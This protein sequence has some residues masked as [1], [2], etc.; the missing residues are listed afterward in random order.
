MNSRTVLMRGVLG[1]ISAPRQATTH[2][3]THAARR[4]AWRHASVVAIE[5]RWILD[6]ERSAAGPAL[7]RSRASATC[8]APRRLARL[9]LLR[10]SPTMKTILL[11]D[12]EENLRTLVRTTL[13]QPGYRILESEDGAAALELARRER[14]DVVVL[15]W[16]MPGM[17]G[18][19]VLTALRRDQATARIPI[20]L[21]TAKGQR[22]DHQQAVA[23]GASAYLMKPF[24]PLQL[25]TKVEE[26]CRECDAIAAAIPPVAD[27]LPAP[28]AADAPGGAQLALYARDLARMV[29][30]EIWVRDR[31]IGMSPEAMQD[32]FTKFY[33]VDKAETRRI[34]GTGLGLALVKEIANAHGGRV[35]V[36][37]TPGAGSTFYLALP[38][39]DAATA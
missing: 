14:P 18:M 30:A 5:K 17:T 31:G 24:S 27:A 2:A 34:G 6:A 25:L 28:A 21:L 33:R 29:D 16:M 11:A 10:T 19:E 37:S 38:S 4:V 23:S 13:D 12:D 3:R 15:D 9:V 1:E 22:A 20:I 36:E 35:W 32:L 8:Q 26:L 39:A 7:A